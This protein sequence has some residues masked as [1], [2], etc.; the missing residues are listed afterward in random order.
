MKEKGISYREAQK[1]ASKIF[2]EE[3]KAKREA[4]AK[5]FSKGVTAFKKKYKGK[6]TGNTDIEKDASIS[7]K[8][9]GKRVS[10]RGK[11]YYEYRDNRTDQKQPQPSDYPRLAKGGS[12]SEKKFKKEYQGND[13]I[14][15]IT[16]ET[17]K[18]VTKFTPHYKGYVID[19]AYP[20]ANEKQLKDF[21]EDYIIS[22][23]KY[24]E[25]RYKEPKQISMAKGGTIMSSDIKEKIFDEN[26]ER[27]IDKKSIEILTDYVN[28]LEQTKSANQKDGE[29]TPSRKKL[30]GKIIEKFKDGVVCIDN[31]KPIAILMGGSPASGKST[32]LKKYA[33]YLLKDEILRIDADEVRAMLP[34]YEGWNASQTHLETKD[35][36]NTLLSDRTIGLPCET[37]IIYDGTMNSNKSYLPLIKLL[38]KMDYKIFV[39]YID[40]VPKDVIVDRA[41]N[42]YKSS[43]RFVPLE[44]IDDFFDKGKTA[45][46][47]IKKKVDGYMIV[48]GSSGDYKVIEEG[49]MKLPKTRKYGKIGSPMKKKMEFGGDIAKS[50]DVRPPYGTYAKGGVTTSQKHDLIKSNNQMIADIDKYLSLAPMDNSEEEYRFREELRQQ[51]ASLEANN[52]HLKDSMM[53]K[54]DMTTSQKNDLIK[55]NNQMIADIDTYLS[56]PMKNSEK[57]YRYR[58]ELREQKAFL[59]ANNLTLKDSMMAKGGKITELKSVGSMLDVDKAIIYP[60]LASGKADMTS[61]M[62]LTE[63]EVSSE[64]YDSL[65]KKDALMVN[66][67]I[68]LSKKRMAKG[69][70]VE[71]WSIQTDNEDEFFDNEEDAREFWESLSEKERKSG[72]YFRKSYFTNEYGELE[73][74]EVEIIEQFAKG[75]KMKRDWSTYYNDGGMVEGYDVRSP[76]GTYAEGGTLPIGYHRMPDGEIMADSE[77]F[78]KGGVISSDDIINIEGKMYKVI[79]KNRKD[80]KGNP[81]HE[82]V[83]Y[84]EEV[85]TTKRKK[86]K[87]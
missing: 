72:Q 3:K 37:D 25:L 46:N 6:G 29:Y 69:G 12:V 27:K 14:V 1:E 31:N 65:S 71:E 23:Q 15:W 44:V 42:R 57:E 81:T 28:S 50:Y 70:M 67:S 63:D 40:K 55:S 38:R 87:R 39:V 85:K 11:V 4:K 47:E 35:I 7:A 66:K 58:E 54:V 2:A 33:P 52:L 21:I 62:S 10:K 13:G 79:T 22:N 60:Q 64:W 18:G 34:E 78:A 82:L 8:P 41:L 86:R 56:Y 16:G 49:G 77:H 83:D 45:L 53:A 61:P 17:K 30:H 36:V 24:N 9:V 74:D 73:E 59:E 84:Y 20:F 51:K 26:G 80:A 32:F 76:Y 75:G 43:G 5:A 19:S 48:D 68:S